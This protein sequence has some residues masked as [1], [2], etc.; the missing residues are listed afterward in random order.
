[1]DGQWQ[2]DAVRDRADGVRK[3]LPALERRCDIED[4]DLV[5]PVDVVARGQFRGITCVAQL[6]EL[7]AFDDLAV[8]DIHAGDDALGQHSASA[9]GAT[10][11]EPR[12]TSR[13]LRM[14]C[15]PASLDFSGWNCTPN[16]FPRSTSH[17][18]P[19]QMPNS[20]VPLRTADPIASRHGPTSAAVAAKLPTPGTINAE[21][22]VSSPG[23]EGVANS[24]PSALSALR[25]DVRLP[26]P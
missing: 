10:S 14:I 11:D 23:D 16:T 7:D 3:R 22:R 18:R 12:A 13:K 17:G 9:R 25:T 19:R 26:A 20:G 15:S 21:N 24:A 4:D 1:A 8:A 6:L 5:D 2:K